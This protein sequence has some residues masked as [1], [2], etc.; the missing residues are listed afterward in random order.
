M[1][2]GLIV[3]IIAGVFVNL[4]VPLSIAFWP[5]GL[6]FSDPVVL[7]I[8]LFWFSVLSATLWAEVAVMFCFLSYAIVGMMRLA[9]V[10]FEMLM[11]E[12]RE[13]MDD[14]NG[15]RSAIS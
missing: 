7:P 13:R 3:F 10:G 1:L 8:L 12:R 4:G 14:N 11:Q 6:E 9:V 5:G 15:N 2:K